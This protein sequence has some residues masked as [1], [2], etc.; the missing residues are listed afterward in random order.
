VRVRRPPLA[1]GALLTVLHLAHPG[2]GA[3]S[4]LSVAELARAQREAGHRVLVACRPGALLAELAAAAGIEVVPV[5]FTRGARPAARIA[6]LAA[7]RR[8]DVVNCHASRDRAACRRARLAGRLP[9]ALVMTRRQLPRSLPPSVVVNGLAADCTVA[10]SASVRRAL[11]RRGAAPWRVRVVPNG[12]DPAVM[13]RR[14]EAAALAEARAAARWS[15][16]RPTIGVVSRRK[17]QA[18]LLRALPLLPRAVTVVLLGIGP[19]PEL[20]ALA[21]AAAPHRVAFVPFRRDVLPFYALFDVAVLPT[22][23]EGLPR[24]LLEAMALGIPVVA[25]RVG[26]TVDLVTDGVDG[27]LVPPRAPAAF[28]LALAALLADPARRAAL[29]AAGRRTVR[30]CFTLERTRRLTDDA[31]RAALER[32]A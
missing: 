30:E 4:T 1:E 12:I 23:G 22:T 32:R 10:V 19:D 6:A 11:V 24:A 20:A 7:E 17:E 31:Y 13:D 29:G 16:D 21:A 2:D 25:S 15:S 26:G 8:V 14:V 5:D 18:V 27:L 28:A 3:G 9:A